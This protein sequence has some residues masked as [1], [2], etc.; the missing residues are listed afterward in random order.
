[1]KIRAALALIEDEK[2]LLMEYVYDGKIVLALP[3]G[4]VE[5]SDSSLRRTV[6][7]ECMEELGIS[8][9]VSSLLV[10]GEIQLP[11]KE[12]VLHCIFGGIRLQGAPV[13]NPEHTSA[14]R[15]VWLPVQALEQ[16]HLYPNVGAH[17]ANRT[18]IPNVV[19]YLG[20]IEQQWL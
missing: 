9:A 4:G 20:R 3:G 16:V 15:V 11:Q 12:A 6:Q 1:M 18:D 8:V 10:C 17:L 5:S 7:R 14:Q 19:V 2:I 13:L